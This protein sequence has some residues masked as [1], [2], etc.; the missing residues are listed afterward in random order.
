MI[1]NFNYKNLLRRHKYVLV[2]LILYWP[3]IFVL[4]HTPVPG[5]VGKMG[6]SD[7]TMHYLAYLI[8]V[9]LL[10]LTVSP[11]SKV[12][13]RKAKVWVVLAVIAWYGATDEWLQGFVNRS[14]D[15]HDFAADFFGAITGL[16]ILTVFSYW[17]AILSVLGVLIFAA[18]NLTRYRMFAGNEIINTSFYFI[19]YS[20]FALVWLQCVHHYLGMNRHGSKRYAVGVSVPVCFLGLVTVCSA[21]IGKGIWW[22]DIAAAITGILTAAGISYVI[23]KSDGS[24]KGDSERADNTEDRR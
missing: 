13:W 19:T 5:F 16:A 3:A 2:G 23:C 20:L 21:V 10:W 22:Y 6:M 12:D 7:K 17:P 9:S 8:L 11:T 1:K 15:V 18:T 14:P 4:T 24:V